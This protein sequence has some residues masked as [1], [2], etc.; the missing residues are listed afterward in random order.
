M[1]AFKDEDLLALMPLPEYVGGRLTSCVAELRE[2]CSHYAGL[3]KLRPQLE[4]AEL[5]VAYGVLRQVNETL[6]VVTRAIE[7]QAS[8]IAPAPTSIEVY[9]EQ[10]PD[11][12]W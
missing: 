11:E 8:G 1:A 5:K 9:G 12:G 6:D 4:P 7:A 3:A 2:L 10:S